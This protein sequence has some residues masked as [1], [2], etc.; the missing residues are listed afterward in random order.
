MRLLVFLAAF[1]CVSAQAWGGVSITEP[2]RSVYLVEGRDM[3]VRWTT[4]DS[5]PALVNIFMYSDHNKD[6][7]GEYAIASSVNTT[8]R[9]AR[10]TSK[11]GMVGDSWIIFMRVAGNDPVFGTGTEVARSEPFEIKPSG[12]TPT[13][14]QDSPTS[15]SKSDSTNGNSAAGSTVHMNSGW[16]LSA[17]LVGAWVAGAALF[18]GY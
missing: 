1:M 4:S 11:S 6:F 17:V 10:I 14:S 18:Y 12:T 13:Q 9:E 16:S 15:T 8:S 3:I 2:N 5:Y 7:V